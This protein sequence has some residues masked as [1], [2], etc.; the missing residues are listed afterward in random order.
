MS[1]HLIDK[2][3]E[4]LARLY[5]DSLAYELSVD[6]DNVMYVQSKSRPTLMHRVELIGQKIKCTCET[7]EGQACKHRATAAAHWFPVSCFYQ[8][9]CAD[10]NKFTDLRHRINTKGKLSRTEKQRITR[11]VRE[12]RSEVVSA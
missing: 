2:S 6:D 9:Q 8:W 5:D 3:D 12:R 11:L 10:S 7:T 4:R 1:N